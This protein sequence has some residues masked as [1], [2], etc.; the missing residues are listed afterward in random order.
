MTAGLDER[1]TDLLLQFILIT[2]AKQEDW[3]DRELGPI[4]LL[5]YAYIA[6]LA[7]AERNAGQTFTGAAWQFYHFGPWQSEIH[8]RIEGALSRL[9]AHQ[10]RFPSRYEGDFVRYA[11]SGDPDIVL[12]RLIENEIP[13]GVAG[14]VESAMHEFGADTASLLQ[15]VYLTRPMLRAAPG[16]VLDLSPEPV[17]TEESGVTV[18]DPMTKAQRRRRTAVIKELKSQVRKRLDARRKIREA[19]PAPRYDEVF[20]AGTNWL[21]SLA[22]EPIRPVEGEMTIDPNVWKSPHRTEPDVP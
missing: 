17:A 12:L 4:H 5:K 16:E 9:N 7:F 3:H 21:D 2:A 13:L 6:D 1:R 20:E 8:N 18:S 10:K 22:G 11:L 19:R 15:H 14:T